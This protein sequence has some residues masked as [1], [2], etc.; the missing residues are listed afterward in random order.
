MIAQLDTLRKFPASYE[1][2]KF[3]TV[4]TGVRHNYSMMFPHQ[5]S[6]FFHV[7]VNSEAFGSVVG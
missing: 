2:R 3:S 6:A 1:T 7:T 4:Y 5:N